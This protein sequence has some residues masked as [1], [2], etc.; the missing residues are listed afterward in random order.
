[1]NWFTVSPSI[2]LS[3]TRVLPLDQNS[4]AACLSG[5]D[6]SSALYAS[7][8]ELRQWCSIQ[9]SPPGPSLLWRTGHTI[10]FLMKSG[11]ELGPA[12]NSRPATGRLVP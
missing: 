1:M 10:T 12:C 4:P 3:E 11:H 8:S 7:P 6:D 2:A 5:S 9:M